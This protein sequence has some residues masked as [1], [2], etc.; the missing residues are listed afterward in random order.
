MTGPRRALEVAAT[1][2]GGTTLVLVHGGTF[3]SRMW[4]RVIPHLSLPVLAVDLPGRRYKPADLGVVTREDWVRSVCEDVSS[5]GLT[6][7]VL[8]G[9]S[10][11]GYVIPGVATA[12]A[13]RVRALV[14][15]AATVPRDGMRPVDFLRPDLREL[16]LGTR[17]YVFE[18]ATGRTLGGLD[19]DEPPI[20][21]ELEVVENG[22]KMGLEA[23][24]PLF[25][26]FSW[27]GF[28]TELPRYFV[29]CLRDR[30]ITPEMVD[31]M[32]AN[33]GGATVIAIDA[34]HSVAESSPEQLAAIVSRCATEAT[35]SA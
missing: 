8:V 16:A 11:A 23:P 1:A 25:E 26:T 13:D 17:D 4:A 22:P 35:S 30:V 21:T 19:P 10:S 31:T 18:S 20:P 33:M 9:H 29:R 27:E 14:F 24:S 2:S 5:A 7:V 15:V 12:L 32:V 34:G 28:P 3:T 6:D